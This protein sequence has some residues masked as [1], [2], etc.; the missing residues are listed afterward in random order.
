MS[1]GSLDAR[2]RPTY[3]DGAPVRSG[4]VSIATSSM[5]PATTRDGASFLASPTNE[6]QRRHRVKMYL[7]AAGGSAPRSFPVG[8]R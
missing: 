4:G 3:S 5:V 8:T 6:L 2:H 7:R 1:A